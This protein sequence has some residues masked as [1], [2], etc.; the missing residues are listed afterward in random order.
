MATYRSAVHLASPQERVFQFVGDPR[1]LDILSPAWISLKLLTKM[2]IEMGAGAKFEFRFKMFRTI[3]LR[4]LSRVAVWEP[5]RRIIVE[6]VRG[7]Y[8]KWV[9][10]MRFQPK[11]DAKGRETVRLAEQ[12]EYRTALSASLEGL[13]KRDIVASF[14]HRRAML[15]KR[16]G[17]VE[18]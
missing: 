17:A 15:R 2:P 16:F 11:Q 1:S 9:H 6:Q 3:P 12:V 18:K 13:A 4:W 7:P 14:S 10:E 8:R 5:P